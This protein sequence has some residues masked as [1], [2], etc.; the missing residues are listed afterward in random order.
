MLDYLHEPAVVDALMAVFLTEFSK[1]TEHA[2]FYRSLVEA[3][4]FDLLGE[5]IYGC[6]F[7]NDMMI[8]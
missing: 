3:K 1:Q 4:I 2:T 5:R 6:K 7:L 8:E